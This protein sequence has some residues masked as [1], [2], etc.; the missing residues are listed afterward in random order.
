VNN[1][2]EAFWNRIG[3]CRRGRAGKIPN[4][5]GSVSTF[6]GAFAAPV[7]RHPAAPFNTTINITT[8]IPGSSLRDAPE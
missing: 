5:A 8:V 7:P 4:W 3:P 2:P 1:L 6:D